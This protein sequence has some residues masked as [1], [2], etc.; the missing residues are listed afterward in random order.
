MSFV[1]HSYV[2]VCHPYFI[3][4][5]HVCICVSS[6]YHLYALVCHPCIT[7]MNSYVICMSLVCGF[8]MN[9]DKNGIHLFGVFFQE[10]NQSIILKGHQE[11]IQNPAKY[12][13][14]S[15]LRKQLMA[16]SCWLF[17]KNGPSLMFDRILNT[18]LVMLWICV[19]KK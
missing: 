11:R 3:R 6:V 10:L 14:W 16:F 15:V 9:H 8:T 7:R 19:E 1:C 4:M 2:L 12:L 17:L 13:I 5:S 18:P